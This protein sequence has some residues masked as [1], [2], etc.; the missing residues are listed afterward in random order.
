M[1]K[2]KFFVLLALMVAWIMLM[3]ELSLSSVIM[4]FLVAMLCIYFGNKF[5]PYKD[6]KDVN[7]ANFATYPF[8]LIGQIYAAGF[9]VIKT[10]LKGPVVDIVTVKTQLKSDTLR[11]VL[12]DS[13]TLTP[14]SIL[15]DLD[16]RDITLLWIRDKY[17]PGDSNTADK[18]LKYKLEQRLI[19]AEKK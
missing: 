15:L 2:Y 8:F 10:I 3:E 6:V 12:A 11:V 7:F 13:I 5:L 4:G 14:G 18:M 16:N 1:V 17:T 19:K 9:S